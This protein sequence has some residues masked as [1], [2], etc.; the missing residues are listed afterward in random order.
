M[1]SV[2]CELAIRVLIYLAGSSK[3]HSLCRISTVAEATGLSHPSVAKTMHELVRGR[4]LQSTKGRRGGFQFA[5]DPAK[6]HLYDVVEAV[7]GAR[8]IARL[9]AP[10]PGKKWAKVQKQIIGYFKTTTIRQLADGG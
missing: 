10:F 4:L 7:D 1:L 6:L 5:R 3:P 2:A 9:D 8:G